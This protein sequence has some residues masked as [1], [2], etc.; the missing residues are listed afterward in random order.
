ME[1]QVAASLKKII[2]AKA[3]YYKTAT[4]VAKMY[5]ENFTQSNSNIKTSEI[6]TKM[7]HST[8]ATDMNDTHDRIFD[9][10]EEEPP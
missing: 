8:D 3:A 6:L 2:T 7:Y 10:V 4:P 1:E 9:S 5:L